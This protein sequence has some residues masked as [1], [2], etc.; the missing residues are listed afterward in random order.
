M[1]KIEYKYFEYRKVSE[2]SYESFEVPFWLK[3]RIPNKESKI[4]DYGCGFGQ[5]M[6]SLQKS[7]Y[8][9]VYGV[10]IEDEAL[11][12]CEKANLNVK[13]LHLQKLDNPFDF[14]FD[15]ILLSHVLEHIPKDAVI[16]TLKVIK[17]KFMSEESCLLIAVPNA[18]SNTDCYWAYEDWTHQT[19]FTAGS[20]YYVLKAAGFEGIDFVDVDSTEGRSVLQKCFRKLF[21][22]LYKGN[23]WF[24]NLVT[25]SGYYR[26]FDDIY[27]Y[28]IKCCAGKAEIV[29]R[30][31]QQA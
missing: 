31:G 30:L 22:A 5:S 19:L 9:N 2:R 23:K 1:E 26:E 17:Q 12:Y 16:D 21:L 6:A 14:K 15:V 3:K 20:L 10:D 28:E 4:L 29:E 7:G 8:S 13:R 18:Q 25:N 11:K 24:W 27:S